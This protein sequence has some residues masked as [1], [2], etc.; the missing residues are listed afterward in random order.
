MKIIRKIEFQMTDS[1][2]EEVFRDEYDYSGPIEYCGGGPSSEQ[3]Q[4]AASQANLT[5]QLA[6]VAGQN[7]TYTEAQRNKTTPFYTNLMNEGPDY[8]N[9]ALDFAGGTNARAFAPEKADLVRRLGMTNG[10]PSGSREQSLTDF[11]EKRATAYDGMLMSILADRQAGRERG[12]AGIMGEAQQANPLGYY[13]GAMSGNQS[14]M[15]APLQRPGMSGLIGGIL[16]A[17]ATAYAGR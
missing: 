3:K 5:N 4:A 8:T 9:Q 15:Q 12:A 17:G 16:G 13:Q 6:T 1:G 10:L 7:E 14:I 11:G 2:M